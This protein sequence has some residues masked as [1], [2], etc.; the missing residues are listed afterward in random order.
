[1]STSPDMTTVFHTWPYG[2]FIEIQSNLRR[3]KVIERIKASIFFEAV[4]A[5]EII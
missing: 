5:I 4:L 1:M 2:K 3:K